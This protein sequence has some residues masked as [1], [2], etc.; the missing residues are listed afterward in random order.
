MGVLIVSE[1]KSCVSCEYSIN[2]RNVKYGLPYRTYIWEGAKGKDLNGDGTINNEPANPSAVPPTPEYKEEGWCF[3]YGEKEWLEGKV[4]EEVKTA[5]DLYDEEGDEKV[6]IG[7][8]NCIT[9]AE[10]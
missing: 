3:A 8:I 1:G 9:G 2:V 5:S 7:A 6:Q 4:F 10:L